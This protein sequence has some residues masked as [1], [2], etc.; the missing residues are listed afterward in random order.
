MQL[1]RDQRASTTANVNLYPSSSLVQDSTVLFLDFEGEHGSEAP[2]L[3][4]AASAD[5]GANFGA[6]ASAGV[7]VLANGVAKFG[8]ALWS[9]AGGASGGSGGGASM[10]LGGAAPGLTRTRSDAVRDLFPKLAYSASDVVCMVGTEPFFS[11]RYLERVAAFSARANAGVSD[12][13][14][15]ILLLVCNR[16][17]ADACELDIQASTAQFANA[18]G[19]NLRTLD[20]FYSAMLAVYLPNKRAFM[21]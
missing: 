2:A 16:R 20:S 17:D 10:P 8:G 11:T 7:G 21:C 6:R 3:L 18:M 14:L 19:E 4:G 5:R 13:D 1:A 9:A 15:P 12:A